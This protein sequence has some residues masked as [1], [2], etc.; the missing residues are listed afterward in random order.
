V[1]AGDTIAVKNYIKFLSAGGAEYPIDLLK[2]AGVNM[3]TSEPFNLMIKKMGS[4]MDEIENIL[5]TIQK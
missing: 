2:K 1:L 3:A 4:V 5:E